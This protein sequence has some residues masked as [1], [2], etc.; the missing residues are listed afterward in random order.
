MYGILKR[1]NYY[2]F[3]TIAVRSAS[4][5]V[6]TMLLWFFNNGICGQSTKLLKGNVFSRVFLSVSQSVTTADFF[7]LFHFRTLPPE[8]VQAC[9][10]EKPSCWFLCLINKCNRAIWILICQGIRVFRF[11][12][13]MQLNS[14]NYMRIM[15]IV[16]H[17]MWKS[18]ILHE[19]WELD[20]VSMDN[21]DLCIKV[22][23]G[24]YGKCNSIISMRNVLTMKRGKHLSFGFVFR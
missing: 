16:F 6:W 17:Y 15:Y 7:K 18:G 24:I 4:V 1:A 5:I 9:L 22:K 2:L 12:I 11:L 14:S 8:P 21:V 23:L 3:S 10:P 13:R 19:K 20:L